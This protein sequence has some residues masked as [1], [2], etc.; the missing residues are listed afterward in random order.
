MNSKQDFIL[1]LSTSNKTIHKTNELQLY[2]WKSRTSRIHQKMAAGIAGL[3]AEIPGLAAGI[4]GLAAGI[5]RA[6]AGFVWTL[7]IGFVVLNAG[8]SKRDKIVG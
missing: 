1:N 4:T 2:S 3:A 5:L 7:K 6:A 8:G